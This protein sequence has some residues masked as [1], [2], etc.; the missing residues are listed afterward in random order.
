MKLLYFFTMP[1][2][3]ACEASKPIVQAECGKRGIRIIEAD[4]TLTEWPENK[5]GEPSMT[6]TLFLLNHEAGRAQ[7]TGRWAGEVDDAAEFSD[8]LTE[9][10]MDDD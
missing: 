6:P 1:G 8:W 5:R 4:L 3:V 2:C 10:W 9:P 7:V